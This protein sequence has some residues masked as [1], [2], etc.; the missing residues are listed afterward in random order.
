MRAIVLD[1]PGPATALEIREVPKPEPRTGWVLL[2]VEAFGLNRSGLAG[3]V[4]V[5]SPFSVESAPS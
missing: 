5:R 4:F 1:A 2:R 3:S